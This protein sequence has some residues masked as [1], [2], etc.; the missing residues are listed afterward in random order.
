MRILFYRPRFKKSKVVFQWGLLSWE[1]NLDIWGETNPGVKVS[2]S[3]RAS[4][5]LHKARVTMMIRKQRAKLVMATARWALKHPVY[6]IV[7][8]RLG[9]YTDRPNVSK[10]CSFISSMN[11]SILISV[12]SGK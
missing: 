3:G 1:P 9:I 2:I 7:I 4:I 12:H 8:L 5:L 6:G 11:S 10:L